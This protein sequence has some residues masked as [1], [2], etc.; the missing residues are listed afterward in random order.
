MRKIIVL[1]ALMATILVGC[2]DTRKN[3]HERYLEFVMHTDSLDVVH[4]AMTVHHEALK[5]DTRTLKERLEDLEDTDSLAILD[6]QKHQ[7]LL[8]E[9]NKMLG[10]LKNLINSHGEM[11]SYFMSDSI[12]I[13][14]ME[15][16]LLEMESNNEDIT[17]RLSDIREELIKIEKQQESM[18]PLKKE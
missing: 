7:A 2:E 15:S 5:A 12:S 1:G 18:S 3:L 16:R 4:D 8:K 14:E 6:L 9:Q 17:S 11:K 10:K 13:E